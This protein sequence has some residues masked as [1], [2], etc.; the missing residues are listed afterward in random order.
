MKF[1]M[2]MVK[3]PAFPNKGTLTRHTIVTYIHKIVI[4]ICVCV[5]VNDEENQ[6][7]VYY[8]K[9]MN[10]SHLSELSDKA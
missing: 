8:H 3:F 2:Y 7:F 6:S 1:F 5:Y 10:V 9:K 4:Y